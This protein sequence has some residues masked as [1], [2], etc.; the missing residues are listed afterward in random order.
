MRAVTDKLSKAERSAIMAKVKSTGNRSTEAVV[1]A[2]LIEAGIEG[3]EKQP[4]LLGKPDFYFPAHRL[5]VFVD[6]CYWH[7]CPKHVRMPAS[8]VAYW[9]SK[10]DRNCRRDNRY[11]RKL[12]QQGYHVMRVWE[13]D[14]KRDTWL[15]RLK[16]MLR[17]LEVAG[18]SA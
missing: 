1:E 8:N 9:N 14:L 11:R 10:I 7:G 12:R 13:H 3:W 17:R 15:K 4:P 16:S 2:A 6:G 5:V 18:D